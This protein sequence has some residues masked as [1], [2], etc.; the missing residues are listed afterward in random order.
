MPP[1]IA[2][3]QGFAQFLKKFAHGIFIILDFA[4]SSNRQGKGDPGSAGIGAPA[5]HFAGPFKWNDV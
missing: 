4:F 5:R 3:A 2:Q 1:D